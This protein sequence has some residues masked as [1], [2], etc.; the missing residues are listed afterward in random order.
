MDEITKRIAEIKDQ[1]QELSADNEDELH[2]LK[3]RQSDLEAKL[4]Q[5][6]LLGASRRSEPRNSITPASV[7]FNRS[8][9]AYVREGSES[10]FADMLSAGREPAAAGQVGVDP[11]GGYFVMPFLSPN[12]RTS[13]VELSD[14]RRISRVVS[15]AYGDAFEEPVDPGDDFDAGWVGETESRPETSKSDIKI[16]RCELREMYANPALTQKLIDD[17]QF[18]LESWYRQKVAAKFAKMENAAFVTGNGEKKPRG[19][20]TYTM[21]TDAD[22]S[23]DWGTLQYVATG[24]S[25]AFQSPDNLVDLVYSLATPYWRNARFV[26]NRST[27]GACRKLKDA[28]NNYIWQRA[29]VAGQPETLLGFPVTIADD[30]PAIAA[31]SYSV[32][33]GDFSR[34]YLVVDRPGIRL[35]RDPLTNK[36]YVYL[37]V[38]RRAGGMVADFNAI[39]ILKFGTS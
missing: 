2:Q 18:D 20:L 5:Q 11:E 1:L 8:F 29:L 14:I 33:F 19:F 9:K 4:D 21:S 15:I 25:G 12:I 16:H 37:Y 39:K 24:A 26:M 36:P 27:A 30:M 34:G 3:K 28:D 32:A 31:N 7:E 22:D 38:Y 10:A 35:L 23:R 6:R 17:A 13:L